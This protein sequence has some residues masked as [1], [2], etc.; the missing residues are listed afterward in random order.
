MPNARDVTA[1]TEF[2]KC[3]VVG[4]PGTGKSALAATFPQPGFV[5]DFSGGIILYRGRNFDYEQYP[6]SAAGWAK[7]EKDFVQVEKD[8]NAGKYE[9]VITDD[10]T[11]LID[12]AM[13][14]ALSLDPKRNAAGGPLWNVH[15]QMCR[16]LI[17]GKFRRMLGWP[18]NLVIIAHMDIVKDDETGQVLEI[19][20]L[21]TGQLA[22]R[23][24]GYFDEVYYTSTKRTGEKVEFLIQTIPIGMKNARSRLSG[25]EGKLPQFVHN[26]YKELM[27]YVKQT[28]QASNTPAAPAQPVQTQATNP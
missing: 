26:N 23:L 18:C 3:L 17:E 6:I 19:K 11:A 25:L 12:I 10:C 27:Y 9:T 24:P 21:I 22:V 14:R 8:V 5:F 7:Y 15:Y 20:P 4:S 13:E 1:E 16:N 2:L 28:K